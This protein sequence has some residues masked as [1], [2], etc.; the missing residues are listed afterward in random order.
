MCLRSWGDPT[1][2]S[3]AVNQSKP[4]KTPF[5]P[6]TLDWLHGRLLDGW[7]H[8]KE[9]RPKSASHSCL[10]SQRKYRF[11][12]VRATCCA[13]MLGGTTG[14]SPG[15]GV[16]VSRGHLGCPNKILCDKIFLILSRVISGTSEDEYKLT[17]RTKMEYN[18]LPLYTKSNAS[19]KFPFSTSIKQIWHKTGTTFVCAFVEVDL[20]ILLGN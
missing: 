1:S 3:H 15:C 20:K 8:A 4:L 9:K 2:P 7:L 13:W 19:T 10:W 12:C 18:P 16:L 11:V 14:S 17:P 5:E 6:F